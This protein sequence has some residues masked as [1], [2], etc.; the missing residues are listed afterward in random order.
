M[1]PSVRA[2]SES[3]LSELEPLELLLPDSEEELLLSREGP[4]EG[5]EPDFSAGNEAGMRLLK[6]RKGCPHSLHPPFD[7]QGDP[8]SL[9][10]TQELCCGA[11]PPLS[12]QNPLLGKLA[13]P[14]FAFWDAPKIWRVWDLGCLNPTR[15]RSSVVWAAHQV[16]SGKISL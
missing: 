10:S 9:G 1:C 12:T 8:G 16:N 6:H 14:L 3:L 5:V 2:H 7:P 11:A 13:P 15:V 4:P